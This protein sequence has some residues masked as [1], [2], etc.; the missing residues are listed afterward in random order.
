MKKFYKIY[1]VDWK[2]N[3]KYLY[4]IYM[5][6][7][8][9]DL[10]DFPRCGDVKSWQNIIIQICQD[11]GCKILNHINFHQKTVF[12]DQRIS[13]KYHF[14]PYFCIFF[15]LKWRKCHNVTHIFTR[16]EIF[17]KNL[18][19]RMEKQKKYLYMIYM[20]VTLWHL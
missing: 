19:S 18:K 12:F 14:Y 20:G 4:I 8:L 5:V 13:E 11:P 2:K 16:E 1:R 17:I 15:I 9:R 10:R 7:D 3:K 6:R